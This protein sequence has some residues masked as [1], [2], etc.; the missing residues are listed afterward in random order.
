MLAEIE[1]VSRFCLSRALAPAAMTR[2]TASR[3]TIEEILAAGQTV[4]GGQ[5]RLR[6]LSD[7]RIPSG[8]PGP[9]TNQPGAQPRRAVWA[10][11]SPRRSR[12]PCCCCAPMC[13]RRG[14]AAAVRNSWNC[15]WRCSMPACIRSSRKKARWERAAIWRPWRIWRWWSSA[16]EKHFYRGERMA[17]AEALRRAGL[18]PLQLPPK[19]GLAL[20]E[21]HPGHDGCGSIG[22][23]AAP[24]GFQ[25]WPTWPAPCRLRP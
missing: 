17:G 9:V 10:S 12:A 11:R 15:W 23:G 24:G 18:V 3:A 14:L 21:R 1:A 25:S 20:Y 4:Y 19:E 5:H 13:W 8:Q 16:R 6:K 2:M 22:R 7:V